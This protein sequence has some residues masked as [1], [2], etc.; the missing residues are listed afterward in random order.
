MARCSQAVHAVNQ[1]LYI[2]VKINFLILRG[3]GVILFF[4]AVLK[5]PT[6]H[7]ES[8][9]KPV[10]K[11]AHYLFCRV[12]VFGNFPVERLF[13]LLTSPPPPDLHC[14]APNWL[15]KSCLV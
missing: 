4:F 8:V 7:G 3:A 9:T 1:S 15:H 2:F 6:G 5:S 11:T 14:Y 10:L 13:F 12:F